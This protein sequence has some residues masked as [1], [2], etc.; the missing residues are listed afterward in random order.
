MKLINSIQIEKY[1]EENKKEAENEFPSIIKRLIKNTVENITDIHIPS[2]NNT[3]Q[4]GVDGYVS[5]KG[6]NK[7]LGD[8]TAN[9]EIGTSK[10][11]IDKANKDIRK[12]TPKK[13]ENF[14]F[15]TPY[16]WNNRKKSKLDWIR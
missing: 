4:I 11:Y 5:F 7:Y 9:I 2:G 12:R 10:N 13:D 8:K 3:M 14:I 6:K 15:I 16:R 1:V